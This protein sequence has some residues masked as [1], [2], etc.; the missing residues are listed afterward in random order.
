MKKQ[1][2]ENSM[3]YNASPEIFKKAE[4]LRKN[5]TEAEKLIW[6]RL[7]K[8]QLGV[9]FKAQQPIDQFIVDFYCHKVNLVIEVDGENHIY[10]QEYDRGRE[11]EIEKFG[12]KIILFSNKEIF[13]DLNI[14]IEKIKALI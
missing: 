5:M 9:R 1:T 4:Y 7:R 2:I 12:I 10:N 11:A 3:F 8:N 6:N 14:I 13:E